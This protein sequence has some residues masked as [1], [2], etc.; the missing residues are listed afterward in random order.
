MVD[1]GNNLVKKFTNSG[2]P[3]ASWGSKGTGNGQ[4]DTPSSAAFDSSGFLY[5]TDTNNK[6]I[7][8]FQFATT[9]PMWHFTGGCRGMFC[10]KMGLQW[11]F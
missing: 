5:V 9:C 3:Q 2:T 11:Q 4:F 6:R 8:K 7:T 10:N 1:T